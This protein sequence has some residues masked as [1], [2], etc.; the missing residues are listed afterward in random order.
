[1]T[2]VFI[3]RFF[4]LNQLY[5]KLV[6]I[7]TLVTF[8]SENTFAAYQYDTRCAGGVIL[9]SDILDAAQQGGSFIPPADRVGGTWTI[10]SGLDFS[11]T[12][13]LAEIRGTATGTNNYNL[14]WVANGNTYDIH[15]RTFD[16][17]NASTVISFAAQNPIRCG[18]SYIPEFIINISG[19]T[20]PYN[21]AIYE[22]G[23]EIAGSPFPISSAG[24]TIYQLPAIHTKTTDATYTLYG[25][26]DDNSCVSDITSIPTI[27]SFTLNA[28]LV[29]VSGS[30]V[31]SPNPLNLSIALPQTNVTYY[32]AK[33]GVKVVGSEISAA[34][35][36]WAPTDMGS[37]QVYAIDPCGGPDALMNGGP[38]L[39]SNVPNQSFNVTGVDACASVGA[40]IGLD[41]SETTANYQLHDGTALVGSPIL[42][43]GGA[44][45]FP[46]MQT[47]GT[48]SVKAINGCGTYDMDGGATVTVNANPLAYTLQD[49]LGNT[50]V[51]VCVGDDAGMYLSDSQLGVNYQVYNSSNNPVGGVTPGTGSG[52]LLLTNAPASDSYYV[53]ATNSISGCQTTMGAMSVSF[54]PKSVATI[55]TETFE[56][57]EGT[58]TTFNVTVSITP[59]TTGPWDIVFTDGINDYNFTAT[60]STDT[61]TTPDVQTDRLFTVKSITNVNGCTNTTTNTGSATILVNPIPTVTLDGPD[62]ACLGADPISI[63]ANVTPAGTVVSNYIWSTGAIDDGK[64]TIQVA[65]NIQ[66]IHS[67]DVE[68]TT[69][70]GCIATQTKDITVNSLPVVFFTAPQ[71]EICGDEPAIPLAGNPGN[72]NFDIGATDFDPALFGQ[73]A[74]NVTYTYTDV[75]TGCTNSDTKQFMVY[76]V[77]NVSISNLDVAY[78][79]DDNSTAIQGNPND[80]SQLGT[81]LSFT[82]NPFNPV[83]FTDNGDGS[84]DFDPSA[85]FASQGPGFYDFTYTYTNSSGC[86]ASITQQTEVLTDLSSNI[87]FTPDIPDS[88]CEDSG[89]YILTPF[90]NSGVQITPADGNIEFIGTGITNHADGTATFDPSIAGLGSFRVRLRFT[91]NFG[92]MGVSDQNI[93]IGTPLNLVDFATEYCS[94]DN[95][96]YLLTGEV[97]GAAPP[98]PDMS[99]FDIKVPDG[100]IIVANAPNGTYN[101]SPATL[102]GNYGSGTYQIIYKYTDASSCNNTITTDVEIIKVLDATFTIGGDPYATAQSNYCPDGNPV[103]LM[104][105]A[106]LTGAEAIGEVTSFF[107]G[108]GVSGGGIN[109]G[110]FNPADGNV[111]PF[112]DPN[113]IIH[114]V[115]HTVNGTSCPSPADTFNVYVTPV[116]ASISGLSATYCTNDADV[117]IS[118]NEVDTL[119]ADASFSATKDGNPIAFLTDGGVNDNTAVIKPSVG[120]GI[121]VITMEYERL[122]DGCNTAI[123]DT[124]EVYDEIP[125]NFSGVS[126]GEDICNSSAVINLVGD[127]PDGGDGNF[128]IIPNDGLT[129]T[130]ADDGLAELD[131]QSMPVGVY[132]IRYDYISTDGCSSYFEKVIN[133]VAGP[134]DTYTVT[135]GGAYCIDDPAPQGLTIGLS[136]S[137]ANVEYELLLGG[138]PLTPAVTYQTGGSGAFNFT[139]NADGTG[140]DKLFTAEGNYTVR[141]NLA[142]CNAIMNGSVSIEQYEL[143]LQEI[144][145]TNIT[146]NGAGDG[147]IE[148]TCT[149]GSGNYEYSVD[150][151]FTWQASN[152]FGGLSPGDYTFSARDLSSAACEVIDQLTVTVIEPE[153]IIITE[154]VTKNIAVGCA[155]CTA[156][157]DCE[158][159]ATI[160]NITG[161]TEDFVTYPGV[162]Y[163]IQWSTGGTLL[164]ETLMPVGTHSVEVT[165]GNGCQE[166]KNIIISQNPPLT[167]V[168]NAGEHE[169]NLCNGNSVGRFV[170]TAG[171]GS[172]TYQFS[173]TDPA[174]PPTTWIESNFGAGGNE[175]ERP[176]LIAGSYTIWVRD[177]NPLYSDRCTAALAIPIVISEPAALS[178]IEESNNTITCNG[179]ADGSFVVR[180]S[181]GESGTF[182]FTTDDPGVVAVPVWN[183]ANN[184]VDGYEQTNL[185]AGQYSVWVR[186]AVNTTCAYGSVSVDIQDIPVLS[187][188]LIEQT[189]VSCNAGND[190]RV[191]VLAQGGSGNYVYQWRN[192]SG[193]LIS[194]DAFIENLDA[195]NSPYELTLNDLPN[196][197][198]PVVQTFDITEPQPLSVV[199]SIKNSDCSLINNGSISLII[200]G[201]TAPYA[202]TWSNGES[203]VEVISNLSPGNYTLEVQD[204]NGCT[205]DNIAAPYVVEQTTDISL[206]Q[207]ATIIDNTC[208]GATEGTIF[209]KVDGGTGN[210][211]FRLEG[212]VIQDWSNPVPATSDEYAFIDLPAGTYDVW[213]RDANSTT[214]A[215]KVGAAY[216]VDEPDVLSLAVDEVTTVTCF[217]DADGAIKVAASGGSGT[218]QFNV[219]N[220]GWTAGDLSGVYTII[221]LSKGYHSIWVRDS[222]APACEYKTLPDVFVDGPGLIDVYISDYDSVSCNGA[223]DGFVELTASGGSGNYDFSKDGGATWQVGSSTV[224]TYSDLEGKNYDF[225]VRD[226]DAIA[227]PA[228]TVNHEVIEPLDFTAV[229]TPTNVKCFGE[230][231]GE[232]AFATTYTD[233]TAGA[234]EYSIDNGVTYTNASSITDLP[235]GSYTVYV[236]DANNGCINTYTT[237][238][239]QP[240][241]LT[242]VLNAKN[243]V[244]CK[245]GNDGDISITVSGGTAPYAIQWY[246]VSDADGGKT[247]TPSALAAGTYNVSITDN[248]ECAIFPDPSYVIEEPASHITLSNPQVTDVSVVGGNDGVIQIDIT[249]GAFPYDTLKWYDSSNTSLGKGNPKT[250]LN[251]DTYRVVAT[252]NDGC[253]YEYSGITVIEPGNDLGFDYVAH[254][255]LPCNG[256]DNGEIH[257]TRVYGGYAIGGTNYRIQVIGPG[258]SEDVYDTKI[259]LKDLAPG[260]YTVTVTDDVPVSYSETI[261]ISEPAP[262]TI[263]TTK[264]SDVS[265]YGGNDGG[266]EV[267]VSGG[268]PDINGNYTVELRSIEGYYTIKSDVEAGVPFIFT[269]LPAGFDTITVTDFVGCDAFDVKRI[270]QPTAQVNLTSS[271]GITEICKGDSLVLA[272]STDPTTW[273]F[274]DGNL[275]VSVYDQETT[276]EYT[277]DQSPFEIKVAPVSSRTYSITKVAKEGDANCLLGESTGNIVTVQVNTLPSATITGPSEVCEDGSIELLVDFIGLKPYT[278]TWRDAINGTSET[279]A[280]HDSYSYTIIDSPA[281]DAQYEISSITDS[282]GCTSSGAGAVDVVI[283][284]KPVVTLTGGDDVCVGDNTDLT[285]TFNEDNSPY[286]IT[287]EANGAEGTLIVNAIAG[288]T[289]TWNMAPDS[290]TTTY[291]LTQIIDGNGCEMDIT[292]TASVTTTVIVNQLP[293]IP[294]NINSILDT[295]LVCQ[296]IK[297]ID[298]FVD[299]V[300]NATGYTWRVGSG[301]TL[302]TGNGIPNVEIDFD[303]GFEGDYIYVK[304]TNACGESAEIERWINPNYLPDSIKTSPI[305]DTDICQGTTGLYYNISLAANASS[306]E[307][308]LPTGFVFVGDS[309]GSFIVVDT[310]PD[311]PSLIG[312]IRVRP[313]N[314]CSSDEPWSLP[315]EIEITPAPIAD[316][317]T[318]ERVC[319]TNATLNA[320]VLNAG[321]VGLWQIVGGSARFTDQVTDPL[322]PDASVYNLSQGANTFVW[323]VTN[324]V[325]QCSTSDTVVIYN[326]QLTV[327]A[328]ADEVEVCDGTV[329][330]SGTPLNNVA[331]A[332]VAYWSTTDGASF[333]NAQDEN[334]TASNM[335]NGLNTF[336]WT[337]QKGLCLSSATVTVTNNQ[338]STPIIYNS[339]NVQVNLV[340]LPCQTNTLDLIGNIPDADESGYWRI[341][342]GTMQV[343][344][345]TSNTISI[346]NI[347][348]GDNVLSWNI[349]RGNCV[350]STTVTI[351]NNAL[352]V[353][354]GIDKESCDGTVELNATEPYLGAEGIWTV[355]EGFATFDDWQSA[356]AVASNLEQ[357]GQG[358]NVL[359]WTL[360]RNGCASYDSVIIYNNQP[361]TAEISGGMSSIAICDYDYD[362]HAVP[363]TYGVGTWSVVSGQGVFVDASNPNTKV[364]QL[365]HGD[366]VLRWT[367]ANGTCTSSVDFTVINNHMDVY[368]GP[369]TA[370][371]G[372]VAE[373]NATPAPSGATGEWQIISGAVLFDVSSE[374]PKASIKSLSYGDNVLV[375]QVTKGSC[376]SYDTV[377]VTNNDPY[378]IKDGIPS[379]ISASHAYTDVDYTT[380][381]AVEPEVGSGLWTLL[382]GRGDIAD[383]T[384]ASTEVTNLFPENIFRWTVTHNGCVESVDIGVYSGALPDANAGLNQ[385]I[386]DNFTTLHG[387]EP[388]GTFG[389]WTVVKGSGT[390]E[391]SNSAITKVSNLS[392]DTTVFRWT[393]RFGSGTS[394]KSDDVIIINNKPSEADA[395]M[396]IESCGTTAVLNARQPVEGN[397]LWTLLSGG[398]SLTD[399][400]DPKSNVSDLAKGENIFKYEILKEQCVSYDT[401]SVFNYYPSEAYAGE[402]DVICVNYMLLNPEIPQYGEGSWRVIEGSG[403]GRDDSGNYTDEITGNY[404]YELAPDTNKL[405]WEVRVPG[406]SSECFTSDT[407]VIVNNEPSVSFAGHDRSICTDTLSLSGSLPVYGKGTWELLS[408]SGTIENDTLANTRVTNVGKGKNR[409][410]WTIDNEGCTSSSDVE[411]SNNL[412]DAFAGY[413]QELC[414]DTAILEG[415]NPLPGVGTWG[416]LGGSGS[417]NFDDNENS[418]TVVRNLDKG[419]NILTWTIDYQGCQSVSEITVTNNKP[420]DA[421]A[422]YNKATCNDYI[423]LA[424]ADPVVGTGKW[425]IRSGGGS[426]EDELDEA[427]QVDS[428]KFGANIF[429]WTVTNE[430]CVST[431][432]VEIS[433][434]RIDAA[435]GEDYGLCSDQTILNA[436]NASPGTGTWSVIGGSSQAKFMDVNDPVSEVYDLAKGDNQLRWSIN[437]KGCITEADITITNHSPSTAYAGNTQ[438][439]CVDNTVM[440]ATPVSIGTGRWEVLT[441]SGVIL[442]GNDTNPNAEISGLAKGDNV[443]RWTVTSDNGLCSNVDEVVI[444]N[445]EPSDPYAGADTEQ[446][447]PTMVLKAA[448]PDFGTGLWSIIEGGGNFNNPSLPNATISN[449]NEGLNTLRWTLT[450]GQCIKY[451]D[452]EVLNNTPTTAN[453][454]PDIEDCKDYAF[455]DANVPTQGSGYWTLISGNATFKDE[456]MFNTQVNNLSFGS[457]VLM[458]NIKKGSCISSDTITVFN[459]V[460][461]Q[462]AAG[463]DRSTCEDYITLNA[464]NP[465][466]GT[467]RWSV[468]SGKGD[469][470]NETVSTSIVR[471]LLLGENQFKWTVS[472]GSCTTEDVVEIIS[473]KANPYAGEDG[474][475]YSSSYE[476]NA[477]NHGSLIGTWTVVAGNGDFEDNTYFN[478]NVR[479]LNEGINTFRWYMNVNGCITY[480]DVSIEYRVVPDADFVVDTAQGCYPLTIQ[481]TNYSIGGSIYDWD[482]GDGNTSAERNP[483]HTFEQPGDY[484]VTL[485]APGPDGIKG[486]SHD[487][488]TVY[489]HPVSDFSYGP[490]VAYIPDDK[491]RFYSLSVDADKYLWNFGDGSTSA[492]VNPLHEYKEEGVFDI[493]LIVH[494][495]FN[496][497]DTIVK[498]ESITAILQGFIAFPSSFM[499]R[500]DGA[501]NQ[502]AGGGESNAVFRPV[503][504]DVE[505]Y[506]LQIY[507]RWGQLIYESADIDEGWNG[508]FNDELSPQAVYI[509]KASGHYISGKIFNEAGSVLLVR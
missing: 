156:G 505:D 387:N 171:G 471:N 90:Y 4:N 330:L 342:E 192:S 307:W 369:D 9:A 96:N 84:A 65:P 454:G 27:A 439:L 150:G 119:L 118:A 190:G 304:T 206:E 128:T 23:S 297:G 158:G 378:I 194:T 446:C 207:A 272:I 208:N 309:T 479:N 465:T 183:P 254:Q 408:G 1:M 456:N 64:Q 71:Y 175:L 457:N 81:S 338:P 413:D 236:K 224:Y 92:C 426:F 257:I 283:N 333:E 146:C 373:L 8:F 331:N 332:D 352:D 149:G 407:L 91:D 126:D 106:D 317:G 489:D 214:C 139:V 66:P 19:G 50:N 416:V 148:L 277:V 339:S 470:D 292:S 278:F 340:D 14:V 52:P 311:V 472:Y 302:A 473:N 386:C 12:N 166:T 366:N 480:D 223:N 159:S 123:V 43:T 100:T 22:G 377:T 121:Y 461:D 67:Y 187:Y 420:S 230:P 16:G 112:P 380:L 463:V 264:I 10:T 184:G 384:S 365:G 237:I 266:V 270:N 493:S 80:L 423:S 86:D 134:T 239:T 48:Y 13:E 39:I 459:Q 462:A 242:H 21:M 17:E 246:G 95:T 412:I 11:T 433:F 195:A 354:A 417:A 130:V 491:V 46:L 179:V 316:A 276:Q 401:V 136:G 69:D 286:T 325:T 391:N 306:Y 203:G 490:D 63:T 296:G 117:T 78:C 474:I 154:D 189:N 303:R 241:E 395:G 343:D 142:G 499:P 428:L 219:D 355:T 243:D 403:K 275:V 135:G 72:G 26:T 379:P 197:C 393:L 38:F 464:N 248:N 115:S 7:L 74:H 435:V 312:D 47:P 212:T 56:K 102:Y 347:A 488:I 238:I 494:N 424:A 167:L 196:N 240:T 434:N 57:C 268:N 429:R 36:N 372:T 24:E 124:V 215:F 466:L 141:A 506:N 104:G 161:G 180:A 77:P 98:A 108:N 173:L 76:P 405:V 431:S 360:T 503:Y 228:V 415:N 469:F 140:G 181:G 182:E 35:Y 61:W 265:C 54:V 497:T 151:G 99:T 20:A 485:T 329:T 475:S 178:I 371:C 113:L 315:L 45:S 271:T 157:V 351:R 18:A 362:L 368:A 397:P 34:P 68:I 233:G 30:N 504:K 432:D 344:D 216:Q 453:A 321:E 356:T 452:I 37:Y 33:D 301:M 501:D 235:A 476:L 89:P 101:F 28:S 174:V 145:T 172:G 120:P 70:K 6:F 443:F 425:T 326:D 291:V 267:V 51:L 486:Q 163:A 300:A 290:V 374:D 199:E 210:Y 498:P 447:S 406:A 483:V 328:Y 467:G 441:G 147:S 392:S 221:G 32:L 402:N 176:G 261:T 389:E 59:T 450:Q 226:H 205:W 42:G 381:R 388:L 88:I 477:S 437:Y 363:A 143:V 337:I 41:G 229:I 289:Y 25:L 138:S 186:D 318:D 255:I 107:T 399:N 127:R 111:I 350:L 40:I 458:W 427:T 73:G 169:D 341:E 353:N 298:Y 250:G 252:D 370:V 82:V 295:G 481:F 234:F 382:E 438:E 502:L 209:V 293:T 394:S 319:L 29:D 83:F 284:A 3:K 253:T 201:G 376:T 359:R 484:V 313:V 507:N 448:T 383:P 256:Y 294:G 314:E 336:V 247:E 31:C 131:P 153:P 155:G 259:S 375:W 285:L 191:E 202:K 93:F 220:S 103:E 144:S 455:L 324:T 508:F 62:K 421:F 500:P 418:Y 282:R 288:L 244:T 299:P 442:T 327:N 225:M 320:A 367:I 188:T 15:L 231:T 509:W 114:T 164:T 193:V 404:V 87:Y 419:D 260:D 53:V 75:V 322:K 258:V 44:I 468:I 396:D 122:G 273:D 357:E 281:A 308:E 444:I 487:T 390:I 245:G 94:S 49:A 411:I 305:G 2:K 5:L 168:E 200:T 232:L 133:I 269:N 263:S 440:D 125:V 349:L 410:R 430:N 345:L 346:T 279:I 482:F 251:A 361:S 364:T 152:I 160:L 165:D 323:T 222:K 449:L 398:G 280:D 495:Q 97:N 451:S 170:V 492:D 400:T 358:I 211:Q 310:D 335:G 460:P 334:T 105:S 116:D 249:G 204:D 409:F 198:G 262:L 414:T 132:T 478:T 185:G 274:T 385:T 213:V 177:K 85:A 436:N 496:C 162:G 287:Y 129:E 79:F 55:T 58:N 218:Y 217:G 109:G 137:N 110:F 422:G 227:C 445:N 60:T 348:V